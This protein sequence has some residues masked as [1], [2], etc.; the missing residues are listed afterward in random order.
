M[1]IYLINFLRFFLLT[2]ISLQLL[3]INKTLIKFLILLIL[4][5]K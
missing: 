1:I 4:I 3:L 2:I 5:D